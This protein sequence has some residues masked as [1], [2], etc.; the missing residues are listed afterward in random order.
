MKLKQRGNEARGRK[1][2]P[3]LPNA[4]K[5]AKL[6]VSLSPPTIEIIDG[7]RGEMP[8]S[9]FIDAIVGATRKGP[10]LDRRMAQKRDGAFY[11]PPFLS[12]Y[13]A[14]KA[15][16]Y[17]FEDAG[18]ALAHN[19]RPRRNTINILDPAC[20]DGELLLAVA[21]CIAMENRG[22]S[23]AIYGIDRDSRAT[24][25]AENRLAA[26][27]CGNGL[28]KTFSFDSILKLN[29]DSWRDSLRG[30][31]NN[32]PP[33]DGFD[34]VIANPPWGADIKKHKA[35]L[36]KEDYTLLSGQVDSADLFLELA[37]N[38]VRPNGLL[39]FIVPDSLFSHE[40]RKVRELLCTKTTL[41]FVARLGEKIFDGINR[42]C[43][44]IIARKAPPTPGHK[45]QV[46]RLNN[47]MRSKILTGSI[48]LDT[49]ETQFSHHIMQSRF[50]SDVNYKFDID[51]AEQE[52][53]I[54]KKMKSSG[55]T[56]GDI[57]SSNR[58][59]ELSK[60][61]K[62]IRCRCGTHC[63]VPKGTM[64]CKKCSREISR[65]TSNVC[66]IVSKSKAAGY[67][68]L[69]AGESVSRYKID[70]SLWVDVTAKGINYKDKS[71]YSD[72]KIVIRKTGV[73]IS[74]TIDYSGATTTQVV[75]ILKRKPRAV[76]SISIEALLGILNSRAMYYYLVKVYGET[77][78]RSH[79]YLTQ[80]QILEL[81]IPIPTE[82]NL[83][84][85]HE[86]E[87]LVRAT[88]KEN[89]GISEQHDAMIEKLVASLYGLTPKDYESVYETIDT[90]Q[91]LLPV[92]ALKHISLID[93][94]G[95]V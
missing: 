65:T 33:S 17:V 54:T 38:I 9:R 90:V 85:L 20:G 15:C 3:N 45:T 12:S 56:I 59:V 27:V 91:D 64:L 47:E 88:C 10:D 42:A 68:K 25:I 52:E 69:L 31:A 66:S 82:E 95:R 18:G 77:E 7:L 78:W 43:A 6:C 60:S 94:F 21:N 28:V 35:V 83:S 22:E 19:G 51:L 49:A 74:A 29:G 70:G 80:S 8:R 48:D 23:L 2:R 1:G 57:C 73:G 44:I 30:S 13:I 5:K 46:L 67:V 61:G 24:K 87:K 41:L 34:V 71:L 50:A 4:T 11:T 58:G 55:Q 79:P 39:A 26:E 40:R 37:L 53:S 63:P 93:I 86:V 89:D 72:E 36:T 32:P 14:K 81:P 76:R 75:Y 92:R 84:M 62:V 16:H